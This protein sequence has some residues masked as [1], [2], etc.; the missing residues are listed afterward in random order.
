MYWQFMGGSSL[1]RSFGKRPPTNCF[2][3]CVND[4]FTV[5]PGQVGRKGYIEGQIDDIVTRRQRGH[6][7]WKNLTFNRV[8]DGTLH[9]RPPRHQG[10]RCDLVQAMSGLPCKVA[11]LLH[12]ATFSIRLRHL[13]T[14]E[15]RRYQAFDTDGK[16]SWLYK[17]CQVFWERERRRGKLVAGF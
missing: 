8:C 9:R 16:E 2:W 12:R 15:E 1:F 10:G 11:K 6:W 17:E 5:G 3:R 7:P 4:L 14:G 13:E